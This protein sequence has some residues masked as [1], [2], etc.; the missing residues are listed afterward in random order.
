MDSN[1]R[2]SSY[3]GSNG[4]E[5]VE[6]GADCGD[7]DRQARHCLA[8]VEQEQRAFIVRDLGRLPRVED[9]TEHVYYGLD[10]TPEAVSL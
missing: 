3:S 1:W 9:R 4:G 10:E 8:A 6:V 2:K 5:C 7:I